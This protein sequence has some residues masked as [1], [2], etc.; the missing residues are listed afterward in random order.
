MKT[1]VPKQLTYLSDYFQLLRRIPKFLKMKKLVMLL[2][3]LFYAFTN[4]QELS[5]PKDKSIVV[6]DMNTI[7]KSNTTEVH[8]NAKSVSNTIDK[9]RIRDLISKPQSSVY[10]YNG[11]SKTYGE[12]PSRLYSDIGSLNKIE[13]SI[14]LKQNI[15]IVTILINTETDLNS[16][17]DLSAFSNFSKLKY[18]Y[19]ISNVTTTNENIAR[20]IANYDKRFSLFYKIDKG[21]SNQ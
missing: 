13:N 5:V 11:V 10:F 8:E 15:E 7:L 6:T 3:L 17:I 14:T 4:A 12:E 20:H 1:I 2:A 21:D 19:F 16:T 18:V 9:Q